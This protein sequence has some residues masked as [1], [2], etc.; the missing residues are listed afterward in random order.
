MLCDRNLF[1]VF[2]F[3]RTV[4][5]LPNKVGILSSPARLRAFARLGG[6]VQQKQRRRRGGGEEDARGQPLE[7]PHLSER[8]ESPD[9]LWELFTE[10]QAKQP[11]CRVALPFP[12]TLDVPFTGTY[13]YIRKPA[14]PGSG[15]LMFPLRHGVL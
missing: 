6:A 12:W 10:R 15:E 2:I 3:F 14:M 1:L 7:F 11:V 9:R 5:S 8:R 13:R 4:F